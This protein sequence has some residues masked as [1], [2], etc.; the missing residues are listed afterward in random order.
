MKARFPDLKARVAEFICNSGQQGVTRTQVMQRF[1]VRTSDLDLILSPLLLEKKIKQ[2]MDPKR[3]A[4]GRPAMRFYGPEVELE[5]TPEAKPVIPVLPFGA[6]TARN[7]TCQVCGVAIPLPEAGRPYVY[8]SE[9]CRRASRD[10]SYTLRDFIARAKDPRV[11]ARVG[12]CLVMADLSMRGF[13]VAI[14]LFGPL[15]R[16]IVHD[17]AGV[18]FLDV[19]V[20][21]DSGYFPPPEEF[22]SVAFVYRD[23]RIVYAGRQPL[24][25]D[26][27]TTNQQEPS[28]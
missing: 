4:L 17:G 8:C 1:Q 23:G 2:Q 9:E 28:A 21:P 24:V 5:L 11:S 26:E 15:T 3:S 7:S 13:Q 16:L 18:A 25:A 22:T 19:L 12:M 20:I 10:G 14:D 27:T 6:P